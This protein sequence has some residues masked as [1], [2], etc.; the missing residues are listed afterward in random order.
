MNYAVF[1]NTMENLRKHIDIK[2]GTTE[3]RR[4]YSS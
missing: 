4:I 1:G 2:L 3:R